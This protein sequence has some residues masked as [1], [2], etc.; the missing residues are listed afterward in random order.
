MQLQKTYTSRGDGHYPAKVNEW[1]YDVAAAYVEGIDVT[2]DMMSETF[3]T[4]DFYITSESDE[5]IGEYT[6]SMVYSLLDFRYP[7]KI[8]DHFTVDFNIRVTKC[9]PLD[10]E[11][12][13]DIPDSEYLIKYLEQDPPELTMPTWTYSTA[14]GVEKGC[15]AT[16]SHELSAAVESPP[17]S[18][19]WKEKDVDTNLAQ[20]QAI[21]VEPATGLT[22]KVP[23]VKFQLNH[24][25]EEQ[26]FV[27]KVN[28]IIN[29]DKPECVVQEERSYN[30]TL[31]VKETCP[32]DTMS[33]P[34]T[35]SKRPLNMT[36][37]L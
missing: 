10:L 27:F 31:K 20:V 4:E 2:Y 15:N 24:K 16:F 12:E 14:T 36:S 13:S 25:L 17:G 28:V 26:E 23:F 29:E 11:P 33:G 21:D 35:R 5:E 9:E 8:T 30:F 19:L 6:L 7:D 37:V 32:E 18:G 3:S 22:Q 34:L 1:F